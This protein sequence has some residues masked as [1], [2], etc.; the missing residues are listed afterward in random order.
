MSYYPDRHHPVFFL[1]DTLTALGVRAEYNERDERTEGC[2]GLIIEGKPF[3]WLIDNRWP[4][5][6]V[7]EDP[8]AAKLMERGAL[9]CCAQK[10]DADRIGAK[11][12]PLAVTP[13]YRPPLDPTQKLY[14]VGFVGYIHDEQ[15]L[16][17]LKELSRHFTACNTS[18]VFG[19]SAVRVYWHMIAPI[20]GALRRWQRERR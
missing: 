10:P 18:G 7:N 5:E 20:C 12:L 11:W 16:A 13:G 19:D 9:V 14:D 1:Q 15:R 3:I 2:W 4:W 8:A 17:I 6:R